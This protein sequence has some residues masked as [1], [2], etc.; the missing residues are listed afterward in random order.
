MNLNR[1]LRLVKVGLPLG[2][3]YIVK[4]AG[5]DA[6]TGAPLYFTKDGKLTNQYSDDDRVSDFGT[7][8]A[9]WIGGFNTSARYKG[10]SLNAF[11]TFQEGFAGLITRTFSSSIM[12]L[13]CRDSI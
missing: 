4:W 10:L 1:A 11:F 9:P 2:S 7:Y 3:H 12:L 13:P 8:N 6:S 5:V